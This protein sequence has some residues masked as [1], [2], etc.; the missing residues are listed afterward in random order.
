MEDYLLHSTAAGKTQQR[1][2]AGFFRF[3]VSVLTTNMGLRPGRIE[4]VRASVG[5]HGVLQQIG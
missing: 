5:Q 2:L 3:L 4:H 1:A